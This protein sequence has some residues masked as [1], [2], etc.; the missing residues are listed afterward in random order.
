MSK[1]IRVMQFGGQQ[2]GTIAQEQDGSL[3]VRGVTSELEQ[4]LREIVS[5]ITAVPLSYVSGREV[6]TVHG[7]R[8]LTVQKTVQPAD[9]DYLAALADA[10][11]RYQLLGKRIRGVL[12]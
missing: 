3:T 12:E 11:S 5:R 9:P 1:V 8:H 6:Q 10:L 7:S 2:A 4:G